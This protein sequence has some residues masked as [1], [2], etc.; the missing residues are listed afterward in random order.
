MSHTKSDSNSTRYI[1]PIII[2]SEIEKRKNR[3]DF[4]KR[5]LTCYLELVIKSINERKDALQKNNNNIISFEES[6][7]YQMEVDL[8]CIAENHAI[9]LTGFLRDDT[10]ASA[11]MIK[12]YE[13]AR[14]YT[15]TVSG[16]YSI[17][18][19]FTKRP[20]RKDLELQS[21]GKFLLDISNSFDWRLELANL[22]VL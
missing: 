8:K 17:N 15:D 21:K 9:N 4:L 11:S 13:A 3:H 12:L 2:F 7:Y 14:N 16:M 1:R 19:D 22:G 20:V 18:R 5:K 6:V 10:H